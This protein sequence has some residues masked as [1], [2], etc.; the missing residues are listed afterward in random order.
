MAFT[1]LDLDPIR[2][3]PS[4]SL[5]DFSSYRK[6]C[7]LSTRFIIPLETPLFM[8]IISNPCLAS[9]R[10]FSSGVFFALVDTQDSVRFCLILSS[11]AR[12]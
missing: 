1:I 4:L 10:A 8:H 2:L 5:A 11:S 6:E 12:E 3:A 7:A 9:L